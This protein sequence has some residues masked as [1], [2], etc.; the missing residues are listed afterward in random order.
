MAW[1]TPMVPRLKSFPGLTMDMRSRLPC[2]SSVATVVATTTGNVT[3]LPVTLLRGQERKKGTLETVERDQLLCF[4]KTGI[5][6][7][8]FFFRRAE[9]P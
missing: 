1:G 3:L 8:G 2:L 6:A 9:R 5:P 4:S 7:K